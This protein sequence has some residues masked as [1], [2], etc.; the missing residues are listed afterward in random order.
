MSHETVDEVR[1]DI[2]ILVD[3]NTATTAQSSYPLLGSRS[4]IFEMTH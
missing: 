2:E 4:R 3:I 1:A